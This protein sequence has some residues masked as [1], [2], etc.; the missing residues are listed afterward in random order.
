METTAVTERAPLPDK[1]Q[2]RQILPWLGQP[3]PTPAPAQPTADEIAEQRR[4]KAAAAA[5]DKL[6][7]Q[8]AQL[9]AAARRW[10]FAVITISTVITLFG[11]GNSHAVYLLHDT[12]NPWAWLPY[13]ALE[14]A[15]IVEI[16]V[17]ALLS[18]HKAPVGFWGAALRVVT[19]VAAITV[20]V[21]GPA[22]SGDWGGAGLHAIGP[23]VQFFLAEFLARARER[24][25]AAVETLLARADGRE[26]AA[27]EPVADRSTR[28]RSRAEKTIKARAARSG[29]KASGPVV[30]D[31]SP[32]SETG[33]AVVLT[34]AE[35]KA[36]ATLQKKG[37]RVSKRTITEQIRADG[38][39]IG[40]T[41]ALAI[42]REWGPVPGGPALSIVE[43]K[44]A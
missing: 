29:G 2:L 15:L 8:A 40:T 3:E 43:K 39:A 5:A 10:A 44:E 28:S 37:V 36:L 25:R 4:T 12:A 1:D 7:R 13:P 32:G 11:S 33:P 20:C 17:G 6:R 24:F 35:K 27:R 9:Q 14:A 21:Y 38:G 18:E 31:R 19:A 23:V 42:A 41:R 16:Q 26:Q 34:P 30:E 22:E